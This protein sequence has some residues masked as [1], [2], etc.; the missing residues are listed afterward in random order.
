VTARRREKPLPK[1]VT[2]FVI[3]HLADRGAFAPFTGTDHDAWIAFL[4]LVRLWGR[5][6][7]ADVV[8]AMRATA[9]A[10]QTRHTD[11]MAVFK[12]S[13]P[14][15]LDWS[16]EPKLW[17]Q[18]GPRVL[19]SDIERAQGRTPSVLWPCRDGERV[20]AHE[21]SRP[22]ER[23]DEPGWRECRDCGTIWKEPTT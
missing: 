18:V 8:D 6:R 13:I 21:R 7:S 14:A 12:K 10:A 23:G 17:L 19:L 22:Y 15:L 20:C 5:T 16:D 4:Y 11:V 3:F 2:D 1:Q 9:H